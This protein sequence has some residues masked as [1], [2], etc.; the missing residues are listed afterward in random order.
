MW[1]FAKIASSS[2]W[3]PDP[4]EFAYAAT[5]SKASTAACHRKSGRDHGPGIALALK[6]FFSLLTLR[7]NYE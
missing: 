4:S 2:K 5:T 6:L 7:T 3:K 1:A